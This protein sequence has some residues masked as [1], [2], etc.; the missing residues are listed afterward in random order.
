MRIIIELDAGAAA[1]ELQI[2]T[3][4]KSQTYSPGAAPMTTATGTQPPANAT[5][6]GGPSYLT[7]EQPLPSTNGTSNEVQGTNFAIGASGGGA[8]N[9]E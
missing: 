3:Q 5:D 4:G 2:T 6:A 9:G 7:A 1:P 8:P